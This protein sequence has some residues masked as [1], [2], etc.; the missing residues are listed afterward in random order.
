MSEP[1]DR[2]RDPRETSDPFAWW[3]DWLVQSERQWNTALNELMGS[4]QFASSMGR[5]M[6]I[7][8]GVQK[9]MNETLG[10]ALTGMNVPNRDD[11]AELGQRLSA[12]EER[13]ARIETLIERG[14]G[15]SAATAERRRPP[16]TRKPP[17]ASRASTP[18][19]PHS[20]PA[21]SS[22]ASP[23]HDRSK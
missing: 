16:R 9:N 2:S 7:Y 6:E 4:D 23:G 19:P 5:W 13:L 15:V 18:P 11:V 14:T 1:K 8:L 3:R 10:R 21:N 12:I 17:T 20:A 22:A